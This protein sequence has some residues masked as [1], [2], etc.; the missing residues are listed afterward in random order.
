MVGTHL[1]QGALALHTVITDQCIHDRVVEAV[2]HMQGA[3]DVRRGN[4]DAVGCAIALWGEIA[5]F[6]PMLVPAPFNGVRLV[7]LV[8]EKPRRVDCYKAGD[9]TQAAAELLAGVRF[10]RAFAV[11][12]SVCCADPF[13]FLASTPPVFHPPVPAAGHRR[14]CPELVLADSKARLAPQRVCLVR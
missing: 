14:H 1:P 9:Y 3:G 7:G 4:H 11:A 12:P 10:R 6:F 5:S 2:T 8:H 13:R